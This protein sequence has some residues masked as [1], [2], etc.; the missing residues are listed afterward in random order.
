[1]LALAELKQ[2]PCRLKPRIFVVNP[3]LQLK[4]EAIYSI[5]TPLAA[6]ASGTPH[7]PVTDH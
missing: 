5:P 1:M 6:Y 3:N 4:L 7:A 2:S